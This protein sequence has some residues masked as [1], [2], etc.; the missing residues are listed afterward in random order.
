MRVSR[1]D[2]IRAIGLTAGLVAMGN[3]LPPVAADVELP[4]TPIGFTQGGV[5]LVLRHYGDAK[6]R[7]LILGGQ[8]GAPEANTI[9]L[10]NQLTEHFVA[11]PDEVPK[12]I[13]LDILAITNPD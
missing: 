1:R 7:V 10:V 8:H 6:T 3:N 2:A 11:H 13:G 5:P 4:W 12:S 9:D